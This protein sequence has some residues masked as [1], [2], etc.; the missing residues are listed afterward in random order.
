MLTPLRMLGAPA[1]IPSGLVGRTRSVA[2]LAT[3]AGGAHGRTQAITSAQSEQ[4]AAAAHNG[5][6]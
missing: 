3:R 5:F 2:F 6:G 4:L 1:L